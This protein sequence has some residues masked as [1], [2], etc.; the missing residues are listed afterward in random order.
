MLPNGA[1]GEFDRQTA[2]AKYGAMFTVLI[3]LG[4]AIG[5][6]AETGRNEAPAQANTPYIPQAFSLC[7][8]YACPPARRPGE[9]GPAA[10]PCCRRPADSGA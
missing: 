7:S 8:K 2:G 6:G 3:L 9:L 4:W 1:A 10:H 5:E